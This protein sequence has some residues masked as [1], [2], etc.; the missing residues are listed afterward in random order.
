MSTDSAFPTPNNLGIAVYSNNA[1]AIGNTP[2]VRINRVISAPVTVLAKIESRNPAFS[3]KCRIGAAL[4][5]DAEKSG[6]LKPGMHI[7]EPTSGNT[8][9]ALAFVAAAKGYELTLTM[10][11]S[12]SIERRKVVKALG[13]NLVLT[14]PAKRMKGAIEA[15]ESLLN[16]NPEKYFLP[17]QFENPANPKIHEETTGPEIWEATAGN[18]DILVTGVGTGGTIT[19][20]SRYFE[21]VKNKPLYSVAVEPA[22]SAIIGQATRGETPPP[23][24]HTV[25]EIWEPTAG[26][27][28]ILVTGVGTGGNITGISRYFEK[29]KN[30]PLYAVAVEPAESA[31]IGQAKRG[32]TLTPGPHKIQGIGANFIPGNLD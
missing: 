10:P 16:E 20:L 23:G 5:N 29:V 15:A 3:V 11:S 14:D 7:V 17:Q 18:I 21:K 13:A 6:K 31:I 24:K 25:R 9:I 19:G 1:D 32:E 28:D 8:G 27:V 4:I 2:L 26:N 12:M 30:K 22:E